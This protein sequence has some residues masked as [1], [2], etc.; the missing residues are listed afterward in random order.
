M[1]KIELVSTNT[2]NPM[3][4]A[5]EYIQDTALEGEIVALV[6]RKKD[7]INNSE[8]GV[9]FWTIAMGSEGKMLDVINKIED[10]ILRAKAKSALAKAKRE[11][12]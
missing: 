2:P 9:T 3:V 7:E 12:T 4:Q 5:F 11:E 8:T 1:G 10:R 6:S